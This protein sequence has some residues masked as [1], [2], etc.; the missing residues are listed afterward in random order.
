MIETSSQRVQYERDGFFIHETPLIGEDLLR[1]ASDGMDMLRQGKYDTGK[2]PEPS[3][4]QP[5][6]APNKFCKIEQPQFA[7]KAIWELVSNPEIGRV[8]AQ[9]TG[10]QMVQVWWV[11]LLIKPPLDQASHV[12]A[13]VGWHQDRNYWNIW[14]EGSELFTAWVAVSDVT[15]E[16]GPMTFLQGSHHWGHLD[17]QS[18]F[19]G[20]DLEAQQKNIR[21]SAGHNWEEFQVILPP[22]GV[23]FHHCLT[24]HASGPNIS[25][26]PRRSFAL[27]MRTEKSHPVDDNREGLVRFIDDPNRCPVVFGTL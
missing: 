22:G 17:E 6:D 20:Q 26:M 4:W 24:F 5:G 10:A 11:Q 7:N 23:S 13:N 12:K 25:G 18:D 3:S 9:I 16:A 19:Y 15:A 2:P 27:H 14:E 1:R 8:A 21:I